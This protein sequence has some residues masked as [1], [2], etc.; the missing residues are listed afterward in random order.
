DDRDEGV[1]APPA[2]KIGWYVVVE[3]VRAVGLIG[4]SL[5]RGNSSRI[6]QAVNK[7]SGLSTLATRLAS[8]ELWILINLI[9]AT[10]KRYS[11]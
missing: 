1:P 11:D 5:R 6:E 9:E 8:D 4:D 10:A 7:L 3:L 2:S